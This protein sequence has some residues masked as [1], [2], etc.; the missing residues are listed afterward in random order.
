[1]NVKILPLVVGVLALLPLSCQQVEEPAQPSYAEVW[2]SQQL[3]RHHT[4]VVTM[5]DE[6]QKALKR[7]HHAE[8]SRVRGDCCCTGAELEPIKTVKVGKAEFAELMDILSQA[9]TPPLVDVDV[10]A[11]LSMAPNE[12]SFAYASVEPIPQFNY[13]CDALRLYDAENTCIYELELYNTMGKESDV[14][15]ISRRNRHG[16]T[17]LIILPDALVEK[18]LNL[19][20]YKKFV[21]RRADVFKKHAEPKMRQDVATGNATEADIEKCRPNVSDILFETK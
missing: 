20:S 8:F 4:M 7:A 11:P 14:P 9:Q 1:M 17:Q 19:P 13:I 2:Q 3:G 15:L 16:D 21:K 6:F 12:A 18:F 10:L 5:F